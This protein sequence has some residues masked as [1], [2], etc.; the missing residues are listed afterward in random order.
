MIRDC[1]EFAA[2]VADACHYRGIEAIAV[3]AGYMCPNPRGVYRHI[4]AANVDL[5]AFTEDFYRSLR[6]ASARR[7]DTLLYLRHETDVAGDHHPAHSRTQRQRRRDRRRR[8]WIRSTSASMCRR[9]SAFHPDD[10]MLDTPP[11]PPATLTRARR[12][13]LREALRFVYAGNV[14]DAEGGSTRCPGC[15]SASWFA[16]GMR[17]AITV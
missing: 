4:D 7:L 1:W 15:G 6:R 14:H 11:T 3:T 9:T 17:C 12:I 8:A 13:G 10:E 16:T 2:D 5:K